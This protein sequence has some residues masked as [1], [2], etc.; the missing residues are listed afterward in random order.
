M[1]RLKILVVD[2]E[3]LILRLLSTGLSADGYEV[4]IARTGF[5]ALVAVEKDLPALIIS[6]IMM[7]RLSGIELLRA[8]KNNP[9]TKQIP[10]ILIS[11]VDSPENIQKGLD[12]GA[13]D[14]ITKPFR[15]NEI[16]GK[17]RH[18]LKPR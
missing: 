17:V 10:F 7:P 15:I 14:Y 8:V 6:D 11:A 18:H 16:V 13:C 2:D 3:D 9:R 5:E 1:Y 12:L 4:S